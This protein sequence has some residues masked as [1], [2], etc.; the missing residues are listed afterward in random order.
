MEALFIPDLKK[1]SESIAVPENEK[2]HLKS[3]RLK[4]GDNITALNGNGIKA[5]GILNFKHSGIFIDITKILSFEKKIHTTLAFAT[6]NDKDRSEFII[7]KGTELGV[8][9]FI[10]VI[11]ER[12]QFNKLK[13]DRAEAKIISAFKQSKRFFKPEISQPIKLSNLL[14]GDAT[15]VLADENGGKPTN[16]KSYDAYNVILLVG[17]EGGFS[18]KE[19]EFL[20]KIKSNIIKWKLSNNRLRAETAAISLTSIFK[21]LHL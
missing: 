13:Q 12:V 8:D 4:S 6:L 2:Q 14:F 7:E 20:H 19:I 10:P 21:V 18:E 17:P 1:N 5:E 15:V 16:I 3:L 9:S 11:S